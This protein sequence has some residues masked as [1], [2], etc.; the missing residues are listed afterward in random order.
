MKNKKL[1]IQQLE[2]R[3]KL[4]SAAG[5]LP[6]PTTGWIRAIRTALG[7]SLRQLGDK[8]SISRQSAQELEMREKEDSITLKSLREAANAMDMELVYGFVPRDGSMEAYIETK[9][10]KMAREIVLRTS[11]NMRLEDQQNS[12][13]RIEQAIEERTENIVRDMPKSLWD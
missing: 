12:D 11:N 4:F 1:Q 6:R 5:Q 13:E 3:V 10:R 7:M 8:L 2:R 9:A